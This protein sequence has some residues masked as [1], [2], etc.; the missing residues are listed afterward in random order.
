MA[1]GTF[2]V[3]LDPN[4]SA[5]EYV[6]L[7]KTKHKNNPNSSI[8]YDWKHIVAFKKYTFT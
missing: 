5:T 8:V 6:N 3:F 7:I 1:R 4:Q 2:F